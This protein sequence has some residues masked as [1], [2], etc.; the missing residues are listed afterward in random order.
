MDYLN[1]LVE[2]L[3]S[4]IQ[5]TDE[6]LILRNTSPF[7]LARLSA[8][9]VADGILTQGEGLS[10][11]QEQYSIHVLSQGFSHSEIDAAIGELFTSI[12]SHKAA[13][14][15]YPVTFQNSWDNYG[16]GFQVAR[17]LKDAHGWVHLSGIVTG[18]ALNTVIFTLPIGCRPASLLVMPCD[19]WGGSGRLDI[20]PGGEVELNRGNV[21]YV[22]LSVQPFYVG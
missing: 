13:P 14:V 2:L 9:D 12:T 4:D 5:E 18:G 8:Y 22:S 20:S 16:S 19:T 6:I 15:S 11:L 10:T 7:S 21:G 3:L 17:I 1:I